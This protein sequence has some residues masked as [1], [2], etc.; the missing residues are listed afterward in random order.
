MELAPE[1][2]VERSIKVYAIERQCVRPDCGQWFDASHSQQRRCYCSPRC[3]KVVQR[4]RAIA[5]KK[6]PT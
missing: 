2:I 4:R 1:R 3:R 6:T 5:R